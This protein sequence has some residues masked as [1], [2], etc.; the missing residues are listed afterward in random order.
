[1]VKRFIAFL[2]NALVTTFLMVFEVFLHRELGAAGWTFF[3]SLLLP[4]QGLPSSSVRYLPNPMKIH[5]KIFD[6]NQLQSGTIKKLKFAMA[7]FTCSRTASCEQF[8]Y[9]KTHPSTPLH[10]P[11]HPPLPSLNSMT[12]IAQTIQNNIVL[13][14]G[15]NK[16]AIVNF[17][18]MV[19]FLSPIVA[20]YHKSR[21]L[22]G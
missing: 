1:M 3:L 22:I 14:G 2:A 7:L 8:C 6:R 10:S 9:I 15:G 21:N 4:S 12:W 16:G 13:R 17:C 19:F 5:N 18:Y 20:S 11:L